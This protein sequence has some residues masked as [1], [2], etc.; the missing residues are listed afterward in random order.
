MS[1]GAGGFVSCVNCG[2]GIDLLHKDLYEQS[3]DGAVCI[4]CARLARGDES[5]FPLPPH[6]RGRLEPYIRWREEQAVKRYCDELAGK[7]LDLAQK[8]ILVSCETSNVPS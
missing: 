8:H 1:V 4:T 2:C 3:S 5:E 6:F 7:Y